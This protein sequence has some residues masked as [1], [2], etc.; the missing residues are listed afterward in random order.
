M[1]SLI[2]FVF[3]IVGASCEKL[4]TDNCASNE[5]FT[6]CGGIGK[7]QRNCM[8]RNLPINKTCACEPGCQCKP[9][10]IRDYRFN[11]IPTNKCPALLPTGNKICPANEAYS[12][13]MAGCQRT[14]NTLN[15]AFKCKCVEGCVCNKG[16]VRSDITNLCVLENDCKCKDLYN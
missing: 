1:N 15:V 16:Y 9:G 12:D 14:C 13:C 7:C 10:F 5:V 2:V 3:F 11:C 8:T 4:C 6:F